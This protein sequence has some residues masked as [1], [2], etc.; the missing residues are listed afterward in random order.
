MPPTWSVRI[1]RSE[2]ILLSWVER[3]DTVDL[4]IGGTLR[5]A[6]ETRTPSVEQKRLLGAA[7]K[8]LKVS[9]VATEG[10]LSARLDLEDP[11]SRTLAGLL[12]EG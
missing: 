5:R 2:H 8:K 10:W 3:A 11:A 6:L 1:N 4:P 9:D 12:R 7:V